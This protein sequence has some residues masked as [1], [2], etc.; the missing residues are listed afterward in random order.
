MKLEAEGQ[1]M[2]YTREEAMARAREL[3]CHDIHTHEMEGR[4]VYMPCYT[5]D[6]YQSMRYNEM[7]RHIYGAKTKRTIPSFQ[8][9]KSR[10]SRRK[11]D[12]IKRR[13]IISRK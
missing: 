8:L 3:G 6:R 7:T 2:Y 4:T 5:H 12:S 11:L 10:V 1:D 9:E 13:N